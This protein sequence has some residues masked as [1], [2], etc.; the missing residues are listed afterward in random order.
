MYFEELI[1]TPAIILPGM[2]QGEIYHQLEKMI[3]RSDATR[4]FFQGELTINE[5]MEVLDTLGVDPH[6]AVDDWD[7]GISYLR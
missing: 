6:Q 1:A 5:F 7:A 2:C 4:L 3:L